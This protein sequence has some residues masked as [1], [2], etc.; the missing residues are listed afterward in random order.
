MRIARPVRL[1][2]ST[3]SSVPLAVGSIRPVVL[4]PA[5]ALTYLT[6]PQLEA[7]LAHELAH[8]RRYDILVNYVQCAI[9][10]LLFYHPAVWWVS[11]QVRTE[12]EHC[13]DDIA[14]E[15][16]GSPALYARALAEAEALRLAEAPRL[17]VGATGMPLLARVR[18][19]LGRPDSRRRHTAGLAA[20]GAALIVAAVAAA[21][22]LGA[23]APDAQASRQPRARN[24]YEGRW[25][26]RGGGDRAE[27]RF[28]LSP[29]SESSIGIPW[30]AFPI[31]SGSEVSE[32]E[33]VR[34]AGTFT[35]LG[36]A[37]VRGTHASGSGEFTFTPNPE[38]VAD[39]TDRG[40][41]VTR[42][43]RI[44]HLGIFDVSR[45]FIGEMADLGHG[46]LSI[47]RYLEFR[48]HGVTPEFIRDL[49]GLGYRNLSAHRLLEF[50]IHGV[51]RGFIDALARLGYTD[52]R[53]S[54]LT[55]FRIH[56]VTP[57]F[58]LELGALGYRDLRPSRLVEFRIHG[59]TPEFILA[60][61]DLGYDNLRPS[62]LVEF[63][64]HGVTPSF[65]ERLVRRGFDDLS[66]GELVDI[67]IHGLD[68]YMRD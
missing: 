68:R 36:D 60:L 11:H 55:E 23:D 14:C 66:P 17:A 4:L 6:P 54:R 57:E 64:I 40:F 56:G 44:L 29:Q 20:G 5:S 45:A 31:P 38:Y 37:I 51:T 67:K 53:A 59:V 24:T 35:F 16:C 18:R 9:E 61:R 3:L 26:L 7:I 43:D 49:E 63:R 48:I 22:L 21:A 30:D 32:F 1:F 12:R 15:V 10:T 25:R 2:A 52:L 41:R 8:I 13:C 19:L 62:R 34:D 42:R 65:I 39:M 33:L 50:R 27:L 46:D 47:Q 58:V 28:S